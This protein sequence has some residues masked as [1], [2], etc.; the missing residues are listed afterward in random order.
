MKVLE[1]NNVKVD[2][3]ELSKALVSVFTSDTFSYDGVTGGMKWEVSG[4]C[5]KDPIIVEIN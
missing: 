1:V 5:E 2:P 3:A 4:A